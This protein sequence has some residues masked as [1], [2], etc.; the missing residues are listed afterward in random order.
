MDSDCV[1]DD[2][3]N[4]Q[5]PDSKFHF[6]ACKGLKR[7][8]NPFMVYNGTRTHVIV[9]SFEVTVKNQSVDPKLVRLKDRTGNAKSAY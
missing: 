2:N 3:Q 6:R 8:K 5:F 9:I 1:S 4:S 7:N